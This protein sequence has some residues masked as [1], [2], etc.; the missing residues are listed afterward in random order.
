M[1]FLSPKAVCAVCGKEC[2]LNRFR[3]QNKEW[4]CPDCFKAA[5][6]KMSTQIGAMTAA[7]VRAAIESRGSDRDLLAQFHITQQVPG[8]L[9]LD[10]DQK[11]WYTPVGSGGKKHPRILEIM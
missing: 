4:C 9:C 7:D 11:L 10:D 2:G 1:G 5:G 3:L 8:F 6:F